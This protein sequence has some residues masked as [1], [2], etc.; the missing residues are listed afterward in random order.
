MNAAAVTVL[1]L[2]RQHPKFNESL[3]AW[4]GADNAIVARSYC[5]A[6]YILISTVD[7]GGDPRYANLIEFTDHADALGEQLI[8]HIDSACS[9][10][11]FPETVAIDIKYFL[12]PEERARINHQ[13]E[14][15]E[16]DRLARAQAGGSA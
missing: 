1:L 4:L 11:G 5:P 3:D 15:H 13:L 2:D 7:T 9:C 10:G 8:V 14:I 16:A 12:E 6:R